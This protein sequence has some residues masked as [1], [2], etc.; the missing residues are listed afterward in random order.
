MALGSGEDVRAGE[1]CG[2]IAQQIPATDGEL[3]AQ[4]GAERG[5]VPCGELF[6][7][8]RDYL[9]SDDLCGG[10]TNTCLQTVA[11]WECLIPTAG[12]F[13]VVLR[14]EDTTSG[15]RA[16]GL[17]STALTPSGGR[18]CGSPEDAPPS[19]VPVN[20]NANIDCEAALALAISRRSAPCS[21]QGC[22][23]AGFVCERSSTEAGSTTHLC[24]FD[25]AR[26]EFE[27]GA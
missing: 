14:C 1:S 16:I 6:D 12:S 24:R 11:G 18:A 25:D 21:E 26:I 23:A 2:T 20:V 15:T 7:V 13:P 3:T 9:T 5:R 27:A 4:V 19:P 10:V 8:I 22:V 17:D